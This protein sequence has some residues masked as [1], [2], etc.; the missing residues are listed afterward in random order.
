MKKIKKLLNK[1][2]NPASNLHNSIMFAIGLTI[3]FIL[4]IK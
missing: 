2:V 1:K 4:I 3:A